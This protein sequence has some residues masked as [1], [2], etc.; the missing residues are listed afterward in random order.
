[1]L[2]LKDICVTFHPGTIDERRALDHLSLHLEKG[3]FVCVLGSNGAGKSTLLNAISGSLAIDAGSIVLD[4][5]ELSAKA[6]HVRSRVIGR[7]FQD[8]MRGTAPD[9]SIVENLG[10]A[11][12]RGK[13]RGLS[14]AIRK[15]DYTFFHDQL[16]ALGL[17]LED[18]MHQP[19]GL[20]SGGQ[21][22][23]LALLMA[24]I[25]T[26][27]LL[28]LDEHTAALDPKT[29]AIVM[30]L[31]QKIVSEHAITTVMITHNLRQSL[32]YGNRTIIMNE[33]HIVAEL[34]GEEKRNAS[35]AQLLELYDLA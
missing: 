3:D 31:T 24:T 10:L 20:L 12:S 18:R 25:V 27:K 17:G 35:I 29:A 16:S 28:L 11:Y 21:R 32:V 34:S 6:E 4:G 14:R 23:A 2:D 19:V 33:G 7:L 5:E 1:M 22:Q 26:P 13:R 8:P 30:D 15:Q 9:M